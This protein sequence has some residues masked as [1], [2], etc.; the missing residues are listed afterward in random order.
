MKLDINHIDKNKFLII[1]S[2]ICMT[3]LSEKNIQNDFKIIELISYN[4][5]QV[6]ACL[7]T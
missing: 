1:Y 2:S 6:F 3:V 4:P 5:E 7:N